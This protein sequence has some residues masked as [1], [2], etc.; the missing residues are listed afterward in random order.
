[1]PLGEMEGDDRVTRNY[2]CCFMVYDEAKEKDVLMRAD[3][4]CLYRCGDCGWNP[5]EAA[6]RM[7]TGRMVTDSAG[8]RHLVFQRARTEAANE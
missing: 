1:M 4:N 7:R 6:R 8:K 5:K 3:V 2:P